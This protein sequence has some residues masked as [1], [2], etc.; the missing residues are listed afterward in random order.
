MFTVVGS[1][2][3]LSSDNFTTFL[4]GSVAR[5]NIDQYTY[6]GQVDVY[7]HSGQRYIQYNQEMTM[8]ESPSYFEAYRPF[9]SALQEINKETM[10]FQRY[11]VGQDEDFQGDDSN[12]FV[13]TPEYLKKYGTSDNNNEPKNGSHFIK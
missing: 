7:L 12:V 9:L 1:L 10:P 3:C 5:R 2:V 4:V 6:D 13:D 11:I 8:I